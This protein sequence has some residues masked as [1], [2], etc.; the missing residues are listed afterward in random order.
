MYKEPKPVEG[1]ENC[2]E[3]APEPKI[4]R[5]TCKK[6]KCLKL[7]CQCF[8]E[9]KFC[10]G[11]KCCNCCNTAANMNQVLKARRIVV[12]KTPNAFLSKIIEEPDV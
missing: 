11:C 5:C 8:A 2:N 7:Y 9:Q 4:M 12:N 3:K 1:K 6:S 10:S